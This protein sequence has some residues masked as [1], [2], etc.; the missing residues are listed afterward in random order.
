VN[1]FRISVRFG[2][3]RHGPNSVYKPSR[4]EH[5]VVWMLKIEKIKE[6]IVGIY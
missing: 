3:D 4:P 5:P 1:G 6:R 2:P